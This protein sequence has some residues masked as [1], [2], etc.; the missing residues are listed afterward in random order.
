MREDYLGTAIIS[1]QILKENCTSELGVND[2]GIFKC[3]DGSNG[4]ELFAAGLLFMSGIEN[5]NGDIDKEEEL[6][7]F[8]RTCFLSGA[9]CQMVPDETIGPDDFEKA[10]KESA[11]IFSKVFGKEFHTIESDDEDE[12][13]ALRRENE[14]L[15]Y[16]LS[17]LE[18]KNAQ[19]ANDTE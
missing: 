7:V 4:W 2:G 10:V 9:T 17:N 3:T 12:I 6:R 11:R 18:V 5:T 8:I 15:R 13:S 19:S 16:A 1:K 14:N